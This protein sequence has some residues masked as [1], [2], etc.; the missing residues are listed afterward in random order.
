MDASILQLVRSPFRFLWLNQV[1]LQFAQN[2][3]NFALLILVFQ[4][5]NSNTLVSIFILSISAPAILFGSFAGVVADWVDKRK[6]IIICDLGMALAA[7]FLFATHA[8]YAFILIASLILNSFI[9][10]FIPAEGSAI[11]MLVKKKELIQAN[12]LFFFTLYGA[13]IFGF[14]MAGPFLNFLGE[15]TFFIIVSAFFILGAFFSSALPPL[16]ANGKAGPPAGLRKVFKI[17][18][19]EISE[20]WRF[21]IGNRFIRGALVLLALVQGMI[22]TAVTLTPGFFERELKI[23][24]TESYVVLAPLGLGLLLGAL[25]VGRFGKSTRKKLMVLRGILVCG[26]VMIL[27]GLLP[28]LGSLFDHSQFIAQRPRPFTAIFSVSSFFAFLSFVLGFFVV[29]IV[30]PAQTILQEHGLEKVRGRIFS[31]LGIMSSV[32]IIFASLAVGVISDLVGI[33]PVV[34]G[35]GVLITLIG[36]LGFMAKHPLSLQKEVI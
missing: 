31:I 24:A 6:L 21:A 22:A 3:L 30:I 7:L 19:R 36:I 25:F 13:L 23:A 29:Q 2:M 18:V 8:N 1:L 4:L 28:V 20:G 34:V 9:Q 15:N 35:V 32:A 10:F 33:L 12:S 11:P 5:T 14:T 16:V 17:T 26:L 27:V